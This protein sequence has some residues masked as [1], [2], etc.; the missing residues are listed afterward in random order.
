MQ[1]A[2]R[3]YI[4]KNFPEIQEVYEYGVSPRDCKKPCVIIQSMKDVDLEK[5]AG[6]SRIIN[7]YVI[8]ERTSFNKLDN[9]CQNIIHSLDK[10]TI[11][12]E[13]SFTPIFDGFIKSDGIDFEYDLIYKTFTFN[14]LALY[15]NSGDK[16]DPWLIAL[17][18]YMQKLLPSYNIYTDVWPTG[19][20]VPCILLRVSNS[21]Q[22][23]INRTLVSNKKT[24]VCH[25]VSTTETEIYKTL[26]ELSF[27]V[28]SD[29]KIPYDTDNHFL[30]LDDKA[31]A[32]CMEINRYANPYTKGQ[33]TLRFTRIVNINKDKLTEITLKGNHFLFYK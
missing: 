6:Y 2:L 26:E 31:E 22:K 14:I 29:F 5:A 17:K 25:I 32:P 15:K 24:I 28:V 21:K 23:R 19:F 30:T 33:L 10:T 1:K 27:N 11:E 7:M 18:T 9:L 4:L 13:K 8:S 20:K 12:G 3:L 16:V